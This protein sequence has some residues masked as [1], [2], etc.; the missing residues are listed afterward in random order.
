MKKSQVQ[1][2]VQKFEE[3]FLKPFKNVCG[4]GKKIINL[5]KVREM[6]KINH[7][8]NIAHLKTK[9]ACFRNTGKNENR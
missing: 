2:N 3:N 5:E 9:F 8:K 4:F 7:L 1:K 6:E